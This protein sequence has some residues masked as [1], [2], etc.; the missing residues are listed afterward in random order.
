MNGSGRRLMKKKRTEQIHLFDFKDKQ[1][2]LTVTVWPTL[3]AMRE[4][5]G[6]HARASCYAY[7]QPWWLGA[8]GGLHGHI[9]FAEKYVHH[10]M[11]GHELTHLQKLLHE[12]L[13]L[14][15]YDPDDEEL[16]A[17]LNGQMST[18][19]WNAVFPP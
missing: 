11:N 3:K 17:E 5:N 12:D 14:N 8:D 15:L 2:F 18:A 13:G 19:L 10:E 1:V 4:A 16:C 6:M 7:I 9:H